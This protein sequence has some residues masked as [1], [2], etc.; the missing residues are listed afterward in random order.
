MS[1]Y[2]NVTFLMCLPRSRSRWLSQFLTRGGASIWSMHDPLVKCGSI[3]ELGDKIDSLLVM[4]QDRPVFV[5]DTM[6][7]LFFSEI[8]KRFPNARYLFVAREP[9]QVRGSLRKAGMSPSISQHISALHYAKLVS[10]ARH[11]LNLC[12]D[13]EDLDNR[14]LN[15]WRFV[16]NT[17]PLD[18]DYAYR[19]RNTNIQV[20]AGDQARRIDHNK[21]RRLFTS[22]GINY[23]L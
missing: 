12:V 19:M 15:I 10:Q 3:D 5:A 2:D 8:S 17:A 16:G 9:Q 14:L 11:D 7:V 22:I 18:G 23:P 13:Y 4:Y 6:A 20:S 21:V 1:R